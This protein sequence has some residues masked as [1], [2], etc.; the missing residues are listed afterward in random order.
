VAVTP[1]AE[2]SEATSAPAPANHRSTLT[3][4]ISDRGPSSAWQLAMTD[5]IPAATKFVKASTTTGHCSG[6]RA[7]TRGATVHCHLAKLNSGGVWRIRIKVVTTG[8]QSIRGHV[9]L[10]SVTPHTL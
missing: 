5:H 4:T 2:L 6:P 9:K 7:G 10:T 8:A 1:Y 3:V